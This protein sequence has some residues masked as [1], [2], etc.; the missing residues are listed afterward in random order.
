MCC[1]AM[2]IFSWTDS[3][4]DAL[5][6]HL[7]TQFS[8]F[9][10]PSVLPAAHSHLHLSLTCFLNESLAWSLANLSLS[11]SFPMYVLLLLLA[12]AHTDSINL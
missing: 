11:V 4:K 10:T 6:K 1:A 2:C 8:T 12:N 3:E 7:T 9:L 5:L